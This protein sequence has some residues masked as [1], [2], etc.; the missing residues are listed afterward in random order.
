MD[1]DWS[2]SLKHFPPSRLPPVKMTFALDYAS[3]DILPQTGMPPQPSTQVAN[4]SAPKANA[5][6]ADAARLSEDAELGTGR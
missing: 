1:R 3:A 5:F 6:A 2:R 4:I